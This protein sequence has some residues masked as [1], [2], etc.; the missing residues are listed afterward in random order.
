MEIE[1]LKRMM[2]IM[3][4]V[5]VN[6]KAY[7]S[8]R[9]Y[10]AFIIYNIQEGV[11]ES[12]ERFEH[13]DL[14]SFAYHG[15]CV[16]HNETLYFYPDNGYGVHAYNLDSGCQKYYDLGFSQV[17]YAHIFQEKLMLF[18]FYAE[19]GLIAINLK[20]EQ[21]NVRQEWWDASRIL[22]DV[23][24][25]FLYTGMYDDNKVWSHC[26]KS[27]YLLISDCQNHLIEK[28]TINVDEKRLY[29]SAYDGKDFWFTVV[30]EDII[31][32][33]NINEGLRNCFKP[34]FIVRERL[35]DVSPSRK[36]VCVRGFV[37]I[38]QCNENALYLLNRE[39]GKMELLSRFPAGV[40]YPKAKYWSVKEKIDKNKLYLFCDVTSMII[41]IDLNSLNVRYISTQIIADK[42]FDEYL[43]QIWDSIFIDMIK[44][45]CLYENGYD[46]KVYISNFIKLDRERYSGNTEFFLKENNGHKIYR[47]VVTK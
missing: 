42:V 11:I 2:G 24:S 14:S 8:N 1:T 38:I 6:G 43:T 13:M 32:Q 25:N 28:Y 44:T 26:T 4:V 40:I 34:G 36:L 27:N 5:T 17:G 39:T 29:G 22:G 9:F 35:H 19:Q 45:D 46:W 10:N 18:P 21:P 31:Y 23:G 3:D 33:W 37:F 20:E 7:I 47:E 15:G 12:V 30:G 41:E 16:A